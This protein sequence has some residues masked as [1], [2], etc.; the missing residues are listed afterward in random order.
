PMKKLK[1]A[2]RL[3]AKIAPVW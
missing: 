3:A 1:L 2:L